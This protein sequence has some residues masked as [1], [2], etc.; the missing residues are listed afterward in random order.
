MF[1]KVS[2][3]NTYPLPYCGHGWCENEDCLQRADQIWSAMRTFI[4][5]F[6]KLPKSKQPGRGKGK[7]FAVLKK[8]VDDPLI[9]AKMKLIEY[10][11][12]KLNE[13][14][15]EFQTDQPMLPFL[16]G[17][18]QKI[19]RSIMNMFIST[20]ANPLIKLLKSDVTTIYKSCEASDIGMGAKLYVLLAVL[21]NFIQ[22]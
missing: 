22:L 4:K 19:L 17:T 7:R 10:L 5:Y 3:S 14:L 12:N 1:E 11:T 13:F 21:S 18:L 15:R 2:E 20:S 8:V 9:Q 6:K 16:C